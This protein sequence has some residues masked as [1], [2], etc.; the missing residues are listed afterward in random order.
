LKVGDYLTKKSTPRYVTLRGVDYVVEYLRQ[1]ASIFETALVHE[2]GDP[3]VQ[4]DE[5]IE[6]E[7]LVR[8]SLKREN[9]SKS[10]RRQIV[11][12]CIISTVYHLRK[13]YGD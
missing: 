9:Q 2:S 3:G 4:F 1:Y 11:L 5:K 7:N 8:L 12:H 13:K 10:L 6:V